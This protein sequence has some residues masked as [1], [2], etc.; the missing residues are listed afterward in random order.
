MEFV[1]LVCNTITAGTKQEDGK[2][3]K[4]TTRW[5]LTEPNIQNSDLSQVT[6]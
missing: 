3:N 4:Q 6:S 5:S 2:V 1:R